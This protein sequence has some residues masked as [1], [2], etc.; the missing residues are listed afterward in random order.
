VDGC[1]PRCGGSSRGC[2]VADR[3]GILRSDAAARFKEKGD[4][5]LVRY[6]PKVK[7]IP[8]Q[9]I[10][11]Q[12]PDHEGDVHGAM[13]W[14][15]GPQDPRDRKCGSSRCQGNRWREERSGVGDD[16]LDGEAYPPQTCWPCIWSGG[17]RTRVSTGH[18]R[19]SVARTHW[20]HAAGMPCSVCFL[21]ALVQPHTSDRRMWRSANSVRSKNSQRKNVR[22]CEAAV[23]CLNVMLDVET[24]WITCASAQRRDLAETAGDAVGID[25]ERDVVKSPKPR[26]PRRQRETKNERTHESVYRILESSVAAS[27]R[28][29]LIIVLRC[30]S[31]CLR[32]RVIEQT[33]ARGARIIRDWT[34]ITGPDE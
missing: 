25:L 20:W 5:Y 30:Y 22:R 4:H 26:K 15:G 3:S 32:P 18:G 9:T 7:F 31:S 21:L 6:H 24:T 33:C 12:G 17:N 27:R 23:D 8:I 29:Q 11:T 28:A 1:C 16:L 10:G 34:L 13:G 14:L 19:C 2:A